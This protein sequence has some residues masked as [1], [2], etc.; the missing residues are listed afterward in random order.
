[1]NKDGLI[2]IFISYILQENSILVSPM[3]HSLHCKDI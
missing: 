1:M 3:V 2:Y